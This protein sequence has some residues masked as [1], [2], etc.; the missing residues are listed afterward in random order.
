MQCLSV[1]GRDHDGGSQLP[2]PHQ[3]Y[4]VCL[5]APGGFVQADHAGGCQQAF[6]VRAQAAAVQVQD[7]H[8]QACV[9]RLSRAAESQS[10]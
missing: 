5:A 9:G 2:A 10:E 7:T 6:Q 8:R 1:S 4:K 3:L